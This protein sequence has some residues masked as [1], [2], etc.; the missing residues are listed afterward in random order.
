MVGSGGVRKTCGKSCSAGIE[1][2][3]NSEKTE[4][5]RGDSTSSG[6]SDRT[7]ENEEC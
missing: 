4:D 1:D 6:F 2:E 5:K 3:D 7:V